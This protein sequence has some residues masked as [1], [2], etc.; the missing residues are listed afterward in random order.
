VPRARAVAFAACAAVVSFVPVDAQRARVGALEEIIITATRREAP[1]QHAPL[2]VGALTE[3]DLKAIGARDIVD[4]FEHIPGLSYTEDSFGGYRIAIRGI[5][6]GT[7]VE[8]RPLTAFYLDETPMMT[9]ASGSLGNPQWGGARPQA[10]DIARVEVIRG[11]QGTLFGAAALGGAVRMITNPPDAERLF[12][13]VEAGYSATA[14]GGNNGSVNGVLNA[15]LIEDRLALRAVGYWRDDAGYVDNSQSRRDDVNDVVTS[16]AR[17]SLL[18]NATQDLTMTFRAQGQQRE[19]GGLAA[20]DIAAGEYEQIRYVVEHDDETWHLYSLELD[21]A[22]PRAQLQLATSRLERDPEFALDIT[23]FIDRFLRVF[24][25]TTNDFHDSVEDAVHELR[26]SSTAGGRLS[27]LGGVYYQDQ[28]RL[29]RQNHLSPGFDALTGGL[30]A[31]FGY[32]DVPFRSVFSGTLRQRAAYGELSYQFN[33]AWQATLGARWFEFDYAVDNTIEGLLNGGFSSLRASAA[34]DGVTPKVGIAYRP[35]ERALVFV[36]IAEGFRPGGINE[37]TDQQVANCSSV[38]TS[39]GIGVPPRRP[40]ES[41]SVWNFELGGK[42]TWLDGRLAANATA[43][44]IRWE[45]MQT[46]RTILCAADAMNIIQNVGKATSEGTEVELSWR[47]IEQLEITVGAAHSDARLAEDAP[48]IAGTDGERIPTVPKWTL[49][50]SVGAQFTLAG[51]ASGFARADYRHV[52]DSWSDF[53]EAV[54]RL[55]PSRRTLDL[56]IGARVDNWQIELFADNVRDERGVLLHT[57][58]IVGEWQALMQ[59]RTVGLRASISL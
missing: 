14:H 40:F 28:D 41:D 55:T 46:P 33:T 12:G 3:P 45:D 56:R 54:R 30:A 53:D 43:Y 27:W 9:V 20:R 18:W 35:S 57:N 48:T 51:R 42:T 49:S 22:L 16:G 32:P 59:P 10:V 26:V 38:L 1:L 36:N 11:P 31:S 58:N 5:A 44:H 13:T 15:P 4:F 7:F 2:S 39:L 19:S 52:D 47:P 17:L 50:A 8:T 34:E 25:P 29:W 37:Y 21:Y 24:N 6:A 23:N